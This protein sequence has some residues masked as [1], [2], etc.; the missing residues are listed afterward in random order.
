[1]QISI[2]ND[3]VVILPSIYTNK[4]MIAEN[5]IIVCGLLV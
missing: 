1:M 3:A 5:E 4:K 2:T